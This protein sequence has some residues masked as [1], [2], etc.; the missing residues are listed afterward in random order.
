MLKKINP[1][2]LYVSVDATD[3]ETYKKVCKPS[4][5]DAWERLMK[6][7]KLLSRFE[8]G[9]VRLTLFNNLNMMNGYAD[10]LRN[11]RFKFL[12]VKAGMS[13]GHAN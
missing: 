1:T 11:F 10:L 13:V 5:D 9:A 3:E 8:R 4:I 12:E 7:L 6:S 2:Q